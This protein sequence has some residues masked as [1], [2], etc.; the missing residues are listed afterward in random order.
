MIDTNSLG[1]IR[2]LVEAAAMGGSPD[3]EGLVAQMQ[4]VGKRGN[5]TGVN[6]A[7]AKRAGV[8]DVSEPF[9]SFAAAVK[10]DS[11]MLGADRDSVRRASASRGELADAAIAGRGMV[12]EAYTQA[13]TSNAQPVN[14]FVDQQGLLVLHRKFSAAPLLKDTDAVLGEIVD[15]FLGEFDEETD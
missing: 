13:I 4:A 11:G 1:S 14:P 3:P 2:W 7:E 6:P 8:P 10:I 15:D 5:V 9:M 12:Q